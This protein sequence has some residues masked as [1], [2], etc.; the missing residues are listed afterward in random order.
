MLTGMI[1]KVQHPSFDPLT[2]PSGTT[3]SCHELYYC[4]L[5]MQ[6]FFRIFVY[7]TFIFVYTIIE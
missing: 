3:A 2:K 5:R 6:A 1:D 7:I 4:F